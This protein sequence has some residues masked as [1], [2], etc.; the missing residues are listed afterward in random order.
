[1]RLCRGW[2]LELEEG[3]LEGR[4]CWRA[5][6]TLQGSSVLERDWA[7]GRRSMTCDHLEGLSQGV[8]WK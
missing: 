2:Y 6:S 4:E 8:W 1:M 3:L 7:M 5:M